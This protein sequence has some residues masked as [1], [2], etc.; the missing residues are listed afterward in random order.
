MKRKAMMKNNDIVV[1]L[2][3]FLLRFLLKVI[4][5]NTVIVRSIATQALSQLSR[6]KNPFNKGSIPKQFPFKTFC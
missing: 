2:A 3:T 4:P 5:C 6:Y 1:H